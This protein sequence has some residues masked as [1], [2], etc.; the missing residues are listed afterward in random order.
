MWPQPTAGGPRPPPTRAGVPQ[1]QQQ[2]AMMAATP[3]P[4][5]LALGS[6]SPALLPAPTQPPT[7][8]PWDPRSLAQ[9]FSTVS[10]TPPSSNDWVFDSGASSHIASNPS[11][12]TPTFSSFP[13][14]IVVGNGATL[15]VVGTG[16][17]TIPGP[18]R[19]N[20]V[21]L[22]PGIIKNLLSVRQFTTDNHVSIEFDPSGISVKDLR[23]R[24]VLLR[25]NSSG[26]LYTLQL[27]STPTAPCV[28]IATPSSS[29][30]HRRLGHPG[31]ET[32]Q[33]LAHSSSIAC[34]QPTDDHL[35][36]ACQLGRHVRLP[37]SSSLSRASK[38]FDLLHCDLWTSPVPSVSGFKYYLVILDDFTHF[39]WTFPLRL[40]SDTFATISNFFAYVRTQ[41]GCPI[42]SIQCD[43]GREFDNFVSRNFFLTHGVSLRMSCP[44]TSQQNGKAER[45]LRTTN[46]IIRTLLFQASM[47]PSYWA[48]A[49]SIATYVLNRLPTKTINMSTPFFALHG[50]LPSY[51]NLPVFGCTC[52]P[53]LTATTPHKLAPRSTLC[54]FLRYSFNHKGY[55]CLDLSS[56][57]VIIS[58]HVIFD[59]TT[60]PFSR[61]QTTAPHKLD[62]L[63]NDE[64][65]L[66]PSSSACT[67][68]STPGAPAQF[69][70]QAAPELPD[71]APVPL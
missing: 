39:L 29:T 1:H 31:K 68:M 63:T 5:Y 41:F 45:I 7:W 20:N 21:L 30:W 13:S 34:H 54:T 26:P 37:F 65:L 6:N 50:K 4:G 62:F 43:N 2:H 66:A 58:H 48:D 53:N 10:L 23:T 60:F 17:S 12:V 42:K 67:P 44:Y 47:P 8:A 24:N 61:H 57:R 46:N 27:P 40:K 70:L 36:H 51:H 32:L 14:S 49:L 28:L 56:N 15:P 16:Y 11:I 35:C 22:A 52:Y 18:Y 3:S 19:F 69:P 71:D 59:E 64:L 25:C 38:P 33:H 9:T 55:R